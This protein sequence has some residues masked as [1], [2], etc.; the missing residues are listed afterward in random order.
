[1]ELARN[2]MVAKASWQE[3]QIYFFLLR[4]RNC[5]H[6][7]PRQEIMITWYGNNRNTGKPLHPSRIFR[8]SLLQRG[9]ISSAVWRLL[10][11]PPPFCAETTMDLASIDCRRLV[12]RYRDFGRDGNPQ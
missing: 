10:S 7:D 9:K 1:M 6:S 5:V 2:Y 4:I 3:K 11:D 12:P 8:V